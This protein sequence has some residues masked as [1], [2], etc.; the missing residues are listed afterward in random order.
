ML[1]LSS[2]AEYFQ[3]PVWPSITMSLTYF[4]AG[5]KQLLKLKKGAKK[6]NGNLGYEEATNTLTIKWASSRC[7]TP[8]GPVS[9]PPS[10]SP[11]LFAAAG[12]QLHFQVVW[13]SH[14]G[15]VLHQLND[16][17][18]CAAWLCS[19]DV[20]DY[21]FYKR[22]FKYR[23]TWTQ[24]KLTLPPRLAPF[25]GFLFWLCQGGSRDEDSSCLT[26]IG[27]LTQVEEMDQVEPPPWHQ[28]QS[29]PTQV[30]PWLLIPDI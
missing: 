15:V 20:S 27:L 4:W 22:K 5:L 26:S 10:P 11:F 12:L 19:T 28:I 2:S 25:L 3:C 8:A 16:P 30:T 29:P 7:P 13:F 21:S 1:A 17:W 14:L 9:A 24:W 6:R 18:L 23:C